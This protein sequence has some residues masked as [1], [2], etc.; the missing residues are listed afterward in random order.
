MDSD[1]TLHKSPDSMKSCIAVR[2]S[3]D[4]TAS[5]S[6]LHK[7]PDSIKS[8]ST[9]RAKIRCFVLLVGNRLVYLR[10]G[11]AQTILRAATLR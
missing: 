1:S 2:E 5:N 6:T 8:D 7:S 10:D 3:P 9:L 11:T 4:S